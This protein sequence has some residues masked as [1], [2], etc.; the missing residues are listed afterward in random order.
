MPCEKNKEPTWLQK[1]TFIKRYAL[2]TCS[3]PWRL[4]L[5]TGGKALSNLAMTLLYVDMYDLL[6]SFFRPKG[7]RTKMHSSITGLRNRGRRKGNLF[8]EPSDLI[9][10][11][12]RAV[13][14]L[15]KPVYS[16]LGT[17][18]FEIDT[19][20]QHL[21]NHVV[22]VNMAT[23]FAYD[24]FSGILAAPDS[25]C[26]LGRFQFVNLDGAEPASGYVIREPT[27]WSYS[28]GPMI[29][30]DFGAEILEGEWLLEIQVS[31]TTSG[32]FDDDYE[33]WTKLTVG[34][35]EEKDCH[36]PMQIVIKPGG[37]GEKKRFFR[38]VTGPDYLRIR[39]AVIIHAG[40]PL[41][42]VGSCHMNA[43]R[44]D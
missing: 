3:T 9:A 37:K 1:V 36:G 13:T 35:D 7:A 26:N 33:I 24:W 6:R 21:L 20:I 31:A 15:E 19:K 18:L 11:T 5:E 44:L 2:D 16:N 38:V 32:T 40:D 25:K 22:F 42:W 28:N 14:G 27:T 17:Y 12:A 39:Q 29:R 30:R 4:Y 43:F 34:I 41:V 23:D 8:P 10:D